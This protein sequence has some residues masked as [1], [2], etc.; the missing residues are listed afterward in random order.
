LVLQTTKAGILSVAG[1]P[2][3]AKKLLPEIQYLIAKEIIDNCPKAFYALGPKRNKENFEGHLTLE[4]V[5]LV[6]LLYAMARQ[7]RVNTL[8]DLARR[9]NT[10]HVDPATGQPLLSEKIR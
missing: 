6:K 3:S 9:I 1:L 10:N 4:Q 7:N 8:T 5:I 2:E